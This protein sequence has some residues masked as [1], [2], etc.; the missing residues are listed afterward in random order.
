MCLPVFEII[1]QEYSG[2]VFS[3]EF[4]VFDIIYSLQNRITTKQIHKILYCVQ[5]ALLQRDFEACIKRLVSFNVYG[6]YLIF[7][8]IGWWQ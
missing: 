4:S 7:V 8:Q 6:M 3:F 2:Y 1:K 5:M